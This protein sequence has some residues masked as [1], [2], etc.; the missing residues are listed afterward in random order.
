MKLLRQHGPNLLRVRYRFDEETRE[1]ME[2]VGLVVQRRCREPE[3]GCDGS[4]KSGGKSAADAGRSVALRIGWREKGLQ[5]RV[6]P[7]GGR[8]DRVRRVWILRREAAER[9]E[10]LHRVAGRGC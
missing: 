9:L 3:A 7:A 10:L 4:R 5:W 8:W 2:T 1:H 6:K